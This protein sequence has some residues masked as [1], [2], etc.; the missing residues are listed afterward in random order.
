MCFR[1]ERKNEKPLIAKKAITC[2]KI[3]KMHEGFD[4]E[5]YIKSLHINFNYNIGLSYVTKFNMFKS[6]WRPTEIYEGF[7]SF[8]SKEKYNEHEGR[9]LIECKIPKGETYY[10]SEIN[11]EYCSTGL[12]VVKILSVSQRVRT[13]CNLNKRSLKQIN[14]K[15]IKQQIRRKIDLKTIRI[16]K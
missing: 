7:H 13:Y 14:N 4:A 15:I 8:I 5:L 2:Y 11:G 1:I 10:I 12:K 16:I 3:V 9:V 6:R